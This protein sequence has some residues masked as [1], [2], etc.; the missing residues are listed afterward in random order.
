MESGRFDHLRDLHLDVPREVNYISVDGPVH[1]HLIV[2]VL[3]VLHRRHR[4]V[5]NRL[6]EARELILVR[7][8][9]HG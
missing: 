9:E 2:R 8:I 1:H 3:R 5:H 4:I 7:L 6:S